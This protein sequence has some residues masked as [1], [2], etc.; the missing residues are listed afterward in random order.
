MNRVVESESV[1]SHVF[2]WSRSLFLTLLESES[3]FQKCWSL[4]RFFKTA[5]VGVGSRSWFFKTA[6]AGFISW[7]RNPKKSSNSTTLLVNTITKPFKK[8]LE[9]LL[10]FQKNATACETQKNFNYFITDKIVESYIVIREI[11][12]KV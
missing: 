3:G 8:M 11:R 6:G 4:S 5:G 10:R 12:I 7:S 2:S 9:K 1:E